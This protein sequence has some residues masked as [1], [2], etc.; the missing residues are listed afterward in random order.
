MI[1]IRWFFEI[2][3]ASAISFIL[4]SLLLS[5]TPKYN[6]T[7]SEE[8]VYCVSLIFLPLLL[9]AAYIS[10]IACLYLR[11]TERMLTFLTRRI[12]EHFF[13]CVYKIYLFEL[14]VSI[15]KMY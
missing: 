14:D 9:P 2:L 13:K 3:Y 5:R 4:L 7:R 8:S 11:N 1:F 10:I 15:I 12:C 6:K